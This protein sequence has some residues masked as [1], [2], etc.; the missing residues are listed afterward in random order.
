MLVGT[1]SCSAHVKEYS[2]GNA[3]KYDE[4]TSTHRE[5]RWIQ[6]I[7]KVEP[8]RAGHQLRV[9]G[10]KGID[11]M[12]ISANL[13]V[14]EPQWLPNPPPEQTQIEG[15]ELRQPVIQSLIG[16]LSYAAALKAPELGADDPEMLVVELKVG[17]QTFNDI[18]TWVRQ[19]KRGK[20][21]MHFNVF[22]KFMR[23]DPKRSWSN[24]YH[25]DV[26]EHDQNSLF[27]SEFGVIV[28]GKEG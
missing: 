5:D 13:K 15:G 6:L 21:R 17:E 12:P 4:E 8:K 11:F 28:E 20:A 16:W 10:Q 7:G 19:G 18:W 2:S 22:G 9:R 23:S 26:G 14:G 24:E 25:W 3:I 27:V 1:F